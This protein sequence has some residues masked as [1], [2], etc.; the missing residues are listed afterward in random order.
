[1]TSLRVKRYD[2]YAMKEGRVIFL[3]GKRNTGK[4]VLL[5]D[6]LSKGPVYDFVLAF[7]PTESSLETFRTFLPECCIYDHFSQDKLERA[8]SVQQEMVARGKKRSLLI[9]MDDCMYNKTV[10]TSNAA[11]SIMMNGR[12]NHISLI[13][14]CQYALDLPSA[15]RTQIDLVFVLKESIKVNRTRLYKYFFG[16]FDKEALFEKCFH[17]CTANYGALV[18][19]NTVSSTTV[20]DTVFWYRADPEP[21][22]FRLCL[23]VYW[24]LNDRC[25]I[26][27]DE[28]RRA[29]ARRFEIE[30]AA[31]PAP[32]TGKAMVV[33]TEDEHGQVVT[34]ST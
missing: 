23:D 3:F 5:K 4:S 15:V 10:F 19:D 11:R 27:R 14:C 18:M 29:Q 21:P 9:I 34:T 6:L 30:A 17:L 1:M 32:A 2:P 7:A 28:A 8:V 26:S 12:H 20:E 22:S 33:E 16:M 24:R 25:G 13:C 31:R